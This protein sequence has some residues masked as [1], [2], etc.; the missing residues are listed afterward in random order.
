MK[1]IDFRILV[2]ILL[3]GA[4]I[5]VILVVGVGLVLLIVPGII[6]GL[7]FAL[8]TPAIIVENI[9]ATKGMGRSKTLASGNLG[10]IFS[11][12]FL[13]WIISFIIGLPFG[14]MGGKEFMVMP[15]QG[16]FR[17]GDFSQSASQAI[18]IVMDVGN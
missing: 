1:R 14:F 15:V 4:G 10:K 17:S 5:L 2:G 13:V 3:I 18:M 12:A 7:W 11:I 6:F 9:G 8:T 16:Y